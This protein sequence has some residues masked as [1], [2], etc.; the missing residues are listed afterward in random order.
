MVCAAAG[1]DRPGDPHATPVL[2][3]SSLQTAA[4]CIAGG[5]L[6]GALYGSIR[7][8]IDWRADAMVCE[9]M[10]RPAGAGARLRFAGD[11]PG[12]SRP[13]ALIVALP[14][15]AEG[16]TGSGL[17]ANVTLVEEGTGRFYSTSDLEQCWADVNEQVAADGRGGAGSRYRISGSV[18]CIAPLANVNGEGS[19]TLD[20]LEF[21]GQ[22]DWDAR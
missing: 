4:G 13:A 1:C 6:Q 7:A 5:Y 14:A 16:G 9:G 11:L 3:D 22:L 15:L 2:P 17:G 10:P 19:V 21:A 20:E 18:Y 8:D 12:T